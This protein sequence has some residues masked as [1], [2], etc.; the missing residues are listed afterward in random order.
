MPINEPSVFLSGS[1]SS[2]DPASPQLTDGKQ[3]IYDIGQ[4]LTLVREC[5][6]EDVILETVDVDF[7]TM[8]P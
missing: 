2:S 7:G 5:H 6:G 4:K 1:S 3:Y 8:V